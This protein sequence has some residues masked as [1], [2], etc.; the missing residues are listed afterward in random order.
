MRL[1][2]KR[3][4]VT[5]ASAGIG[6]ATAEALAEVGAELV[7]GARRQDRLE[8]TARQ[9]TTR[10]PG[11]RLTTHELDVTDDASVA[12]FAQAVL[13]QGPVHV[14]V[15]NAGLARGLDPIE[16][17]NEADWE[18]TI[19]TNLTGVLRLTRAFLPAMVAAKEGHIVMIGSVAGMDPYA[20]GAVYCATKAAITSLSRALRHELHG[21]GLRVSVI[22][23]GLV[24]TD[25]SLVRFKGDKERAKKPYQGVTPLTARDVAECVQFA[26]TRPAH[27]NVEEILVLATAQVGATKVFRRTE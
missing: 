19:D 13:A 3:A 23:P 17:G 5:G 9:I 8:A 6:A 4:V 7:L 21:T 24:E 18:E 12:R 10:V 15:N 27:V 1:D 2:G 22:D 25:F 16:K 11:A 26:V 14:L 20:G